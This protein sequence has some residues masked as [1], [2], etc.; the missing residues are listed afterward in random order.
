MATT[1]NKQLEVSAIDLLEADHVVL[2]TALGRLEKATGP[3]Q[4]IDLLA[5]T[6]AL[7][8]LHAEGEEAIFYPAFRDAAKTKEDK[9]LFFEATEEHHL[10][11]VVI[12]ELEG[13]SADG[14]VFAAKAKVLKDLVE[15]HAEE[16]EEQM[17]PRARKLLGAAELKELG[18]RLVEFKT[19]GVPVKR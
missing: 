13:A 12:E 19:A 9:K 17:F 3:D 18:M 10:V 16:E 11:D 8:V 14:P 2:R 6:K 1:K 5:R 7:I 4:R 15:H